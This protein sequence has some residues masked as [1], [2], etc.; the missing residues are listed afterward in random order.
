M[1]VGNLYQR[2]H[3]RDLHLHL[4]VLL[5]LSPKW[6][7]RGVARVVLLWLYGNRLVR[8]LSDV[9]KRWIPVQFDL[10]QI[11]LF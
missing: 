3:D 2:R 1:V 4:L 8:L 5:L 9:G 10:R 6:H 11:H 7:E